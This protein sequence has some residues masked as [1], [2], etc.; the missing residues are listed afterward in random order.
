MEG[1]DLLSIDAGTSLIKNGRS[2]MLHLLQVFI[3]LAQGRLPSGSPLGT[4]AWSSCHIGTKPWGQVSVSHDSRLQS[5][6][7]LSAGVLAAAFSV[8]NGMI[9]ALDLELLSTLSS[10][11]W[12]VTIT[13]VPRLRHP[14][15]DVLQEGKL[16][17]E[18]L[19]D[20][21]NMTQP[22]A[23]RPSFS[24]PSTSYFK[25]SLLAFRLCCNIC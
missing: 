19:S 6:C 7:P 9:L 17:L 12:G 10:E 22:W 23:D 16:R 14:S 15:N 21:F 25:P 3:S 11:K 1:G 2:W 20:L 24:E 4:S 13:S 5:T 18:R 8:D